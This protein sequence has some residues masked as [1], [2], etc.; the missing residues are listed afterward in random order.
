MP[1]NV[2]P[3]ELIVVLALVLLVVGPRPSSVVLLSAL[4]G[5]PSVVARRMV[6]SDFVWVLPSPARARLK[7]H[8]WLSVSGR[9]SQS[10]RAV[11]LWASGLTTDGLCD[12]RISSFFHC[13]QL[14]L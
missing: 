4:L 6:V 5:E 1:F 7:A 10:P 14:L 2:G 3:L 13:F 8:P 11:S 9:S 12:R